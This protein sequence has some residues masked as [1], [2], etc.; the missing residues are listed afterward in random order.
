MRGR[1]AIET[2]PSFHAIARGVA[3]S[4]GEVVEVSGALRNLR[5]QL[6]KMKGEVDLVIVI[7]DEGLKSIGPEEVRASQFSKEEAYAYRE[8]PTRFYF[9]CYYPKPISTGQSPLRD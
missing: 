9:S 5:S 1:S 4:G 6:V 8:G 7:V 2:I 3:I